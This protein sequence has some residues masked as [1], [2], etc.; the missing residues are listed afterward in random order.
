MESIAVKVL[1]LSAVGSGL[2]LDKWAFGRFGLSR[3]VV[4]C[5][6]LGIG[7]GEPGVGL[8]LGAGIELIWLGS[9]P[10]GGRIAP[11][12]EGAGIVAMTSY[13]L[14]RALGIQ[15]PKALF[16][17]LLLAVVGAS[18]GALADRWARQLNRPLFQ[19]ASTE[20]GRF[21]LTVLHLSGLLL[22]FGAGFG[23]V[24]GGQL[25]TLTVAPLSRYLPGDFSTREL[26]ALPLMIGLASFLNLFFSRRGIPFILGGGLIGGVIWLWAGA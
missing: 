18:A 8:L 24:L 25:L 15:T 2:W 11:D 22:T 16:W 26:L 14:A 3:P 17:A 1:L 23:L 6:L 12:G 10:L 9:L 5:G 20:R 7:F 21:E 19:K 4:S 13:L